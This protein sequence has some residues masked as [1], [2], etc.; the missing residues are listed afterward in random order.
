MP[1]LFSRT[2]AAAILG[3]SLLLPQIA[4]AHAVLVDSTPKVNETMHGSALHIDLKFNS[5]VD[6]ARST[7]QLVIPDGSVKTL[8]LATQT[9]PDEIVA[10]VEGLAKGSYTLHWQALANDGHITR[11][12]IPFQVEE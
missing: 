12:Q 3:L 5:R 7:V 11:G 10:H 4:M 9:S 2:V 8:D 1:R 6:G